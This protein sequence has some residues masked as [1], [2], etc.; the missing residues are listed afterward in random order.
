MEQAE[1]KYNSFV[2]N[3]EE[4]D[5]W[6][7]RMN[8]LGAIGTAV[9]ASQ[10]DQLNDVRAESAQIV[11]DLSAEYESLSAEYEE[12]LKTE[13]DVTDGTEDLNQVM[14]EYKGTTYAVSAQVADSMAQ[15]DSAYVEAYAEAKES[16][17]GQIGLFDKLEVKCDETVGQMA[18]NMQK[19]AEILLT[20][21][22]DLQ[23]AMEFVEEGTF[24][25][26][27]LGEIEQ[28]GVDG[29]GYLHKIVEAAETNSRDF[30][31]IMEAWAERVNAID[32]LSETKAEIETG[33]SEIKEDL[34][35]ATAKPLRE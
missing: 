11:S 18:D 2:A 15:L 16:I 3:L 10:L 35:S 28:M 26:E 30:D 29:A 23:K 34:I 21:N 33:C 7:E 4:A 5:P 32:L 1:E 19:Q 31:E 9:D 8:V 24:S 6:W 12:F 13:N 25:R 14:V 22:E 17:E 20:Y 27:F